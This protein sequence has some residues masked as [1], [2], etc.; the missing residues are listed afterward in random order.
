MKNM[1]ANPRRLSWQRASAAFTSL[2]AIGLGLGLIYLYGAGRIDAF[3]ALAAVCCMAF[4]IITLA[5]LA[6]F[7]AEER[8]RPQRSLPALRARG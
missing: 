2:V 5:A 8:R 1:S 7:A 4:L 6:D 3:T